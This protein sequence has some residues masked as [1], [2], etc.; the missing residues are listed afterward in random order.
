MKGKYYK[1]SDKIDL[2]KV[3]DVELIKNNNIVN[4]ISSGSMLTRAIVGGALAGGVGAIVRGTTAKGKSSN[5]LNQ[6]SL[7]FKI[8]DVQ[9]PYRLFL[10]MEDNR[11]EG[12][13]KRYSKKHGIYLEKS[14]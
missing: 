11:K 4:E 1:F 9:N 2:N 14:N 12:L 8:D 5:I 6:I 10:L 13:L 7:R 3:I